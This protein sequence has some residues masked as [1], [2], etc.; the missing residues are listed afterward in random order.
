[1]CG[2]MPDAVANAGPARGDP[3]GGNANADADR[4]LANRRVAGGHAAADVKAHKVADVKA[5][6]V[7]DTNAQTATPGIAH[8][9]VEG[10]THDVTEDQAHDVTAGRAFGDAQ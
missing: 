4:R 2:R 5:H 10:K 7:S 1:M 9:V 6:K 3:A 8:G